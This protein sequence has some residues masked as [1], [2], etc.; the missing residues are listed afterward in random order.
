MRKN[1]SKPAPAETAPSAH[2]RNAQAEKLFE[3][4]MELGRSD[5]YNQAI[6]AFSEAIKLD[7]NNG[8]YYSGRGHANFMSQH[9]DQALQDYNK[10]L[11]FNNDDSLALVMR[12]HT[13]LKLSKFN[14]AIQDYNKALKL[15]YG[16]ADLYKGRGS[17][18]AKLNEP[19]NMCADFRAACQK[20]DC[21]MWDNARNQGFC[22]GN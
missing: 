12:G 14:N 7:P 20:G 16:D 17:A 13:N 11:S 9:Y 8:G 21:E 4:G 1:E 3:K 6:D 5:K 10:A 22:N 19:A 15:G 2:Q 18:Y